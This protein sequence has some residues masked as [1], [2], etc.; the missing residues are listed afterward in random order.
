MSKISIFT[1][2]VLNSDISIIFLL[3]IFKLSVVILDTIIERTVSQISFLGLTLILCNLEH[4]VLKNCKMFP[5]FGH[6]IKTKP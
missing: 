5:V 3:N 2:M 6:K 1:F 4:T